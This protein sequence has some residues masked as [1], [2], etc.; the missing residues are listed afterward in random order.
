MPSS[1]EVIMSGLW[2]RALR[3]GFR[4]YNRLF[5]ARFTKLK[6]D[7]NGMLSPIIYHGLY[8]LARRLPDLPIV[9]IGGA[10]GAGSVA[11]AL[12]MK[13][14]GKRS[15][16]IVVEKMEGG[17][18]AEYGG[19]NENL[20]RIRDNFR[21]YGVDDTILLFP[22]ALTFEN[23]HE[24]VQL[25]GGGKIA[26]FIH[27]ADGRIDRDFHLF[28]PLL[29]DGG[30]IVVDDYHNVARFQATDVEHPQGGAKG[31]I[32]YRLLNQFIAW[33]LFAKDWQFRQTIFGHKPAGADFQRLD[34][35]ACRR[36]VAQVEHERTEYLESHDFHSA[37]R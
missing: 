10:A 25:V 4:L 11:L 35:D 15:K 2:K 17:S 32:T 28:W 37:V 7:T 27:D 23:G 12:G 8:Q 9:E 30:A 16:L 22:E 3:T 29:Q 13:E 18:R 21:R 1:E 5:H 36:I 26:A 31:V 14:S 33:G 20:Q 19:Y 34:L 24:V 6:Q